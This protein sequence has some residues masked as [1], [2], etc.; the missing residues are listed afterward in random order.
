MGLFDIYNATHAATADT[1]MVLSDTV[2]LPTGD[3]ASQPRQFSRRIAIDCDADYAEISVAVHEPGARV[4]ASLQCLSVHNADL[5]R[6]ERR[7]AGGYQVM[8]WKRPQPGVYELTVKVLDSGPVTCSV[9]AFVQ[10]RLRLKFESVAG[11]VEMGQPIYL[12]FAIL[13]N[14]K[15]V[16]QVSVTAHALVPAT[17]VRLLARDWKK[18]MALPEGQ[19]PDSLPEAVARALAVRTHLRATTGRDPFSCVRRE[20]QLVHPKLARAKEAGFAVRV[21]TAK[22]IDGTYAIR[23]VAQGRTTNGCPFVRVGLRS[24]LVG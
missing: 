20:L 22:S 8:R 1:D 14:G 11:R 19:H 15:P 6:I 16:S 5:T 2:A 21:P 10:S 13:D 17:S 18:E 9:A 3:A 4:D 23:L 24:V 7:A 12:P